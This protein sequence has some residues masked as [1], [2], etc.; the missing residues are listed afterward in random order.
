VSL[1]FNYAGR[2]HAILT[3][4][5]HSLGGGVRDAF[6]VEGRRA[7][8]LRDDTWE[9]LEDDPA[10]VI[11]ALLRSRVVLLAELAGLSVPCSVGTTRTCTPSSAPPPR[12]SVDVVAGRDATAST[13]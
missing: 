2:E 5:D 7:S 8:R 13:R 9:Q 1:L 4:V 11:E 10:A 6:L 3:L 12:T